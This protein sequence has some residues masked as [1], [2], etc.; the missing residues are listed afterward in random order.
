VKPTPNLP[1]F[2]DENSQ[3]ESL[4]RTLRRFSQPRAV[5]ERCELCGVGLSTNHRHILEIASSRIV[6]ACDPCA[7]RFQDV[8]GSR[9]KLIPNDIWRLP[10]LSVS[11]AE[12]E[13]L[14][15]PIDLA[16]FFRST[17]ENKMK[18]L[19]PGPAGATE[20]LLPLAAWKSVA[21]RNSRLDTICPDVEAFL[22]NRVRTR[23]DYYIVPIDVC[24]ELVGLIRIH[25]RGLSGGDALWQEVE[26]FF[27]RLNSEARPVPPSF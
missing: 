9:F 24:F 1:G 26:R 15:L 20:S 21:K 18:A 19:Y 8:V 25:W 4:V 7:F 17:P 23:R 27:A 13:N 2:V 6:C 10:E 5:Q 16:F 22:V 3:R 14:A 11:D 12:W